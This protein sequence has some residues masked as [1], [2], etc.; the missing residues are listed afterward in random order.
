M[1]KYKELKSISE[2]GIEFLL[3]ATISVSNNQY[4]E[5]LS[6]LKNLGQ[7]IYEY[8]LERKREF[9]PNFGELESLTFE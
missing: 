1:R 5:G 6:F 7:L 9:E 3:T 4:Q 2:N 8:E